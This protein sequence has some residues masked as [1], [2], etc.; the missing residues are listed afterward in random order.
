MTT[1][2]F[3]GTT[4]ERLASIISSG[5]LRP[6][7]DARIFVARFNWESCLAHG[8]DRVR[9]LSL[10]ARMRVHLDAENV[11]VTETPGARDTAIICTDQPIPAEVIEVFVRRLGRDGDPAELIT[12]RGIKAISAFLIAGP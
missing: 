11:Q 9:K 2:Y 12:L 4:A 3:H 8:A 7:D 6:N 5:V 10:V 1:E